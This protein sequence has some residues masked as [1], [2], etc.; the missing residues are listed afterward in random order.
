MKSI[1][2]LLEVALTHR[3]SD[4]IIKAGAPPALRV[5]GRIVSTQL[6]PMTPEE[7]RECGYSIIYSASRDYLLQNAGNGIGCNEN[8][9]FDAEARLEQ[10]HTNTELDLVFTIRNLARIRANLFLERGMIAAALRIIPLHP[11]TIDEL[12]LPPILK[13]IALQPQGLIIITGPTGS[14]KTTTLAAILEEINRKRPCNI[15]TIE[16]PIEYVFTDKQSIVH[17]REVGLDTKS[18]ATGLRSVLRQSPDVIAIGELRDAE[19]MDVAMTASEIGHLVVTTLHTVSAT[20]TVDRI[21]GAFPL[22]MRDQV[23]AQLAASLLCI[24]SQRLVHKASG[25]GRLPAVEVL[26]NSPTVR[27]QIEEGETGE[28]YASIR[29]GHHYGMNTMNQALEQLYQRGLITYEEAMRNA[30]NPAELKQM[31]RRV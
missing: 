3:A 22:H 9:L 16:E 5:D 20:A 7:T 12:G 18:F 27:K 14:G 25:A 23:A 10:L 2:A 19:T 15:F 11:L 13:E 31:L 29:E 8:E 30:G 26:T 1:H 28:L 17:Q 21:I 24:T 6:P 4:L